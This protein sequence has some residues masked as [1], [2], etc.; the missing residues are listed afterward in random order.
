MLLNCL[1]IHR[2]LTRKFFKVHFAVVCEQMQTHTPA[3]CWVSIHT[4]NTIFFLIKFDPNG[5]ECKLQMSKHDKAFFLQTNS[6]YRVRERKWDTKINFF[7]LF[8]SSFST[9]FF[10]IL[11]VD[12]QGFVM[13]PKSGQKVMTTMGKSR[14][15]NCL[16]FACTPIPL[17]KNH[18]LLVISS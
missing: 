15:K 9:I 17:E 10:D 7:R 13:V 8:L 5:L 4:G 11:K 6:T 3:F 14:L 16:T 12:R 1:I 18:V 2:V